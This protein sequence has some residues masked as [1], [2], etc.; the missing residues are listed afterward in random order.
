MGREIVW[1]DS[2]LAGRATTPTARRGATR[3][4]DMPGAARHW[5][6]AA[7]NA[8]PCGQPVARAG[9]PTERGPTDSDTRCNARRALC[10]RAPPLEHDAAWCPVPR[11]ATPEA[12][13]STG[14]GPASRSSQRECV[15]RRA[16]VRR[17]W[18]CACACGSASR[19]AR[20]RCTAARRHGAQ[21]TLSS[22][23]RFAARRWAPG[24]PS[25]A[26][27]PGTARRCNAPRGAACS[28]RARSGTPRTVG[29]ARTA[30]A[31]EAAAL[32][33]CR[34]GGGEHAA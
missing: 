32:A 22:C 9:A 30:V 5:R 29:V 26:H 1:C 15:A 19:R 14:A 33:L 7:L 24:P 16:R 25:V 18:D 12:A 23:R 27:A 10:A 31:T 17:R 20:T 28:C 2:R 3:R 13:A 8:A 34:T 6:A 11:P 4:L 21:R